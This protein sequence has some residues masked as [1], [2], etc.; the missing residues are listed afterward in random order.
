MKHDLNSDF[1]RSLIYSHMI[2]HDNFFSD[3]IIDKTKDYMNTDYASLKRS[4]ST[5][6]KELITEEAFQLLLYWVN[7]DEISIDFFE[8][9]LTILTTFDRKITLPVD[10][11]IL[12]PMIEMMSLIGYKDHAI[13][14]A[15]DIYVNTPEL[16]TKRF[17]IIH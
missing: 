5:E 11:S 9:F 12:S 17:N 7:T 13:Y 1:F 15:I 8:R 10:V 4:L 6:E 3:E 14:T 16:L 2:K